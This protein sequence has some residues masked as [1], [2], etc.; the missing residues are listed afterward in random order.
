MKILALVLSLLL[1]AGEALA[2]SAAQRAEAHHAK[3]EKLKE[4]LRQ[5]KLKH[6][7]VKARLKRH[8]AEGNGKAVIKDREE[9]KNLD[10]QMRSTKYKIKE[11]RRQ[12]R[13]AERGEPPRKKGT[14]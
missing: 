7:E 10:L 12:A 8:Q 9:L 13:E 14:S 11:E 5:E 1:P 6:D 3:A 2:Q 4:Q